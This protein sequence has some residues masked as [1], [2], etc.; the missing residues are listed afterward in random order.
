MKV[1]VDSNV[2]FSAL[3]KVENVFRY[4]L[5]LNKTL[6]FHTCKYLVIE[7]FKYKNKIFKLSQL[8]ED[9]IL[10]GFYGILK[11]IE[12]HNEDNVLVENWDS[13]FYLCQDVDINDVPFVALTLE[14]DGLLWTGDIKLKE[15]LKQKGFDRFFEP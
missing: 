10:E 14:L 12:L 3:L 9:Q 6:D 2:V 7:L 4:E 8:N 1:I 15:S 11:R 5:L 13:A